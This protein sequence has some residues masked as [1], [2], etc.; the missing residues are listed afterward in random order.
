MTLRAERRASKA[1]S[2][3]AGLRCDGSLDA[4]LRGQEATLDF[5]AAL[6]TQGIEGEWVGAPLRVGER[7]G[8]SSAALR[9]VPLER[10]FALEGELRGD[11]GPVDV[12]AALLAIEEGRRYV[13]VSDDTWVELADDLRAH[14]ERLLAETSTRRKR[15]VAPA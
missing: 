6:S 11:E 7:R 5:L 8:R 2:E 10:W 9:F 14:L 4:E 1:L 12:D 3:R 15:R 13:R